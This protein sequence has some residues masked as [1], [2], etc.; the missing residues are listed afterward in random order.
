[1]ATAMPSGR[2]SAA[3]SLAVFAADSKITDGRRRETGYMSSC[4]AEPVEALSIHIA[5]GRSITREIHAID[6]RRHRPLPC[7][8]CRVAIH[9]SR[10]GGSRNAAISWPLRTNNMSPMTTGW[11]QVFPSIAGIRDATSVN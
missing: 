10:N 3:R 11:F 2:Q 5:R 7:S 6:E 8:F 4:A 9:R 1:M